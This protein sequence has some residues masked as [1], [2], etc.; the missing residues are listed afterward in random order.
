MKS[1][2]SIFSLAIALSIAC[3]ASRSADAPVP[4]TDTPAM[5]QSV[6]PVVSSEL[7]DQPS[8]TL[9]ISSAPVIKGLKLGMTSDEVLALFPGSKDDAA[10]RPSISA[11]PGRF[12][13]SSFVIT[14]S[15]YGSAEFEDVSQ[16]TFR[17][18]DG[19]VSNFTVNYKGPE[20]PHVDK[21]IE[22]FIE[23]K[24]L[25]SAEQWIPYVGM[26]TQMKTLTCAEFSIRLFASGEGG[27]LNYAQLQDLE[28]DKK[29]KDRQKKAREQASPTPQ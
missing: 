25:P 23:D 5:T 27:K 14:P 26:D 19:R 22:K 3:S 8:C 18:L 16:V 28:A 10:L 29:L 17:L 15:K 13:N 2:F 21:F 11:P 4:G 9:K 12:G 7:Q 24:N 6:T 20:W 1:V